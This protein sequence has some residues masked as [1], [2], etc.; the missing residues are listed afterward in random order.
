MCIKLLTQCFE[1]YKHQMFVFI[2]F[3]AFFFFPQTVEEMDLLPL[4]EIHYSTSIGS[5]CKSPRPIKA[6]IPLLGILVN[7]LGSSLSKATTMTYTREK[8]LSIRHQRVMR[9]WKPFKKKE[10]RL[11]NQKFKNGTELE[12]W[13]WPTQALWSLK[14]FLPLLLWH[15]SF[16]GL[17]LNI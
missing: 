9:N 7:S 14:D 10:I 16:L 13:A 3:L 6:S 17:L 8:T 12:L 11:R 2:P 15:H 1:Y 4:K 5:Y